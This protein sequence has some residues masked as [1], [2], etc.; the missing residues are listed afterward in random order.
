MTA[1][2]RRSRA[3]GL[4]DRHGECDALDRLI[5]AVRSGE[6]RVLAVR[7]D[8]GVGKPVLVDSLA[9]RASGA[10]CRVARAAGVQS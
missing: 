4:V 8:P 2:P 3:T 9:G 5:A 7:G 10:E 1:N 6:S